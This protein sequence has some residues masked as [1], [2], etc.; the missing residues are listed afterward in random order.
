MRMW[1]VD[2]AIMCRQHLLG[3][4]VELHMMAAHL[5]LG[6]RTDKFVANNCTQPRSIKARH[7]ALAAE[8]TR[9][10][11]HHASPLDQPPVAAHQHPT[12]RVDVALALQDLL[13]RCSA[14]SE[15]FPTSA[16]CSR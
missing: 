5:R 7:C 1:M 13:G 6:R 12:A 4:H 9:R 10:G 2:P 11:Y 3:E 16:G 8:M 14:C 15:R